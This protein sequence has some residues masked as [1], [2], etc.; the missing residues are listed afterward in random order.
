MFRGLWWTFDHHHKTSFYYYIV[1]VASHSFLPRRRLLDFSNFTPRGH[2]I[3]LLLALFRSSWKRQK[4]S[5]QASQ[6]SGDAFSCQRS[7]FSFP[8]C[9]N[10]GET[11]HDKISLQKPTQND[12]CFYGG[13]FGTCFCFCCTGRWTTLPVIS[14]VNSSLS[15]DILLTS[16]FCVPFLFP[17]PPCFL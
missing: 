9:Q 13:I 15:C 4:N 2:Y 14:P 1:F 6:K 10:A 7:I 16:P 11:G 3:L 12:G 5:L 17:L 8:S